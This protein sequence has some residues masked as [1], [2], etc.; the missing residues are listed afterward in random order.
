MCAE[1]VWSS[2]ASDCYSCLASYREGVAV[3]TPKL[4]QALDSYI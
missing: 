2:L 1:F 4:M 3:M